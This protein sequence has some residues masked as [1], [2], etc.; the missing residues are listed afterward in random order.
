MHRFAL[1][2]ALLTLAVAGHGAPLRQELD[3]AGDWEFVKAK[4]LALGP[5]AEGWAPIKV[6][7]V[8][9]GFDY[10][11]AWFRR[12]FSVPAA[13]QGSRLLLYFGGVKF[14][15]IVIVNG[16]KV[17]GHYGGYEPFEVDITAVARVGAVNTLE[18]GCHDWTGV[19]S[20]NETDFAVLKQHPAEVR[21]VPRD[22][23][24]SP[25]GGLVTL[26]GPWDRV[27]LKARPAVYVKDL[28]VKPSVRRRRL[29][30]E[31]TLANETPAPV[32]A[33]L[34]AA[35]EDGAQRALSLPA[36]QVTVPASAETNL[37]IEAPWQAPRLWSP[38]DPYLYRL[39]T[40]L[41]LEGK[42]LDD[43]TTRFGFR[44]FW[45]EGPRFYL[46]GARI[47]LLATSWW[48]ELFE[49]KDYI[50][51]RMK[52]IKEAG[53]VAFRTHT[54]PWP[55]IW[56]ET[57]DEMGLMMIPEGAVWNDREA[58]RINDPRFWDNYAASLRAMVDRDKN[59][60]SVVMYSLENEFYG[61]RLSN[62]A[63]ATK[64]LARL[65]TLMH[66]WDPTRPIYYESDGDPG[67]VAD[68]VGLHYPHEYPRYTD[69]PNTAWWMAQPLTNKFFAPTPEQAR[70]WVWD[71]KKPLYIGEFLWIP[72][73]DPSW[74]TVFYGDEAYLDYEQHRVKA[75]GDSWR[76]AIQAY[77]QYEVGG[78]S[79]W[80]MV[81]GGPLREDQNPMY[82]AQKYAMQH[83]AVYLREYDHNFFSA[84]R[85]ARTADLY[86]DTL[87]PARLTVQW[88]LADG[89]QESAGGEKAFDLAAGERREFPFTVTLPPVSARQ[90]RQLRLRVVCEGRPVFE[91]SKPWSLFPAPSLRA[92]G[93]LGLYDPPGGTLRALRRH[94]LSPVEVSDLE[95]IP[96]DLTLLVVGAGALKGGERAANVIGRPVEQ[97]GSLLRY[98]RGGGRL[99]VL[100]QPAY[101]AGLLPLRLTDHAS[102]MTFPQ[103][104]AHPLLRGVL[105]GDL[106]FW[107]PDNRVSIAEPPRPSQGGYRAVVVSGSESGLAHAPLLE[108]R[109]GEGV[110]VLSQLR[111]G[112]RLGVEPTAGVLLQN[113]LDYLAAFRPATARAALFCPEAVTAEVLTSLGLSARNITADPTQADWAATDLLIA[114]HPLQGLAE[115]AGQVRALLARGGTVVFHG[116]APAEEPILRALTPL[117]LTLAA[118]QGSVARTR[119]TTP[120][121]AALTN[122][123]FYWLG[124]A[125]GVF[126]WATR[127]RAG[128]MADTVLA[129][130]FPATGATRYEHTV[131]AVSGAYAHND[132]EAA[133]LPSGGST[134]ALEIEVPRAG[135]YLLGV[136]A[137]GSE[138]GGE[139]PA[140]SVAIDGQP[141]GDFACQKG[142][143][144]TYAVPAE[145]TAGKHRVAIRFAND[146][147]D[148]ANR[149]DRNLA[150]KA[151][152]LAPDDSSA[153]ANF[154]TSPA[155]L[156]EFKAG[157][158]AVV[159]D[160]LNWDKTTSNT[161]K[162]MRYIAGLL[163]AVGAPFEPAGTGVELELAAF[164]PDPQLTWFRRSE[165]GLYLGSSGYV[166]GR[167]ECARAGRYLLKFTA[168]GS[169]VKGIFPI[170][171]VTVDGQ[172][173]GQ[174]ELRTDGWRGYPLA[175]D[176]AAGPHDLRL[177]F[178]N[179]EWSPPE[180]R[181]LWIG[182]IEVGE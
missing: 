25:V 15:S 170:F 162:A 127:P 182:R 104:P 52:A 59:K 177:T 122:E 34:A 87:R 106:K 146:Y 176:F 42:T 101:P 113:A 85:V 46:N 19:F 173:A 134:A 163:T 156:A 30:V 20:D 57:A 108:L 18:L 139:W 80:T 51:E 157:P 164:E 172:P 65:G 92:A 155:A 84:D 124:S 75:K 118:Y 40:R 22:K 145:L 102:T 89:G 16:R 72:S 131:M 93:R 33:S 86:N 88:A 100:E 147:Y 136:V 55:E 61:G 63:P 31:Y 141:T 128:D 120:L 114:C 109:L 169:P 142:E 161:D 26:Y 159:V 73:S 107:R 105:P 32:T 70:S 39:Q 24:L 167:V 4:D 132:A 77:R 69:W 90:E 68:V 158:G 53:C 137:G 153:G 28:F 94:G 56:Y 50:R 125:R 168:K 154:L 17:G 11:R 29:L 45:V 96:T 67:G 13:M 47:N 9:D 27:S 64:D 5:P 81:E 115:C 133:V 41:L 103:L 8:L 95:R 150:V 143:F 36:R 91:D 98:V 83:Q 35:V 99:L 149:Q 175:V 130:R 119:A 3:L 148:E 78:I 66:Q 166:T 74:H 76:M 112:E 60:P 44:E 151:L 140:G 180:D 37:T 129:R 138:A 116:V 171:A 43:L 14:N 79:P 97:S 181:N 48:P 110:M 71:R 6:P 23:V 160:C 62:E 111:L 1:P 82:A 58:Y 12:D 123:D 179:D 135:A 54:Q 165:G 121:A 49:S 10:E 7:G 152:L 2:I 174:V 21:E 178:T 117:D 144:D 38:E 126:S